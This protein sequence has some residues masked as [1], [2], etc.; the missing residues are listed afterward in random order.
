MA[1]RPEIGLALS[2]LNLGD[3]FRDAVAPGTYEIDALVHL[4]G[5][6]TVKPDIQDAKVAARVPWQRICAV[7][8][9]KLNGATIEAVVGEALAATEGSSRAFDEL[10]AAV[11]ARAAAA[12][13]RLLEGSRQTR[14]GAVSVSL[15]VVE[16][17]VLEARPGRAA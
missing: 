8:L 5:A 9:S 15:P 14:R 2:K 1:I 12:V 16:E 17:I 6:M 11:A 4:K 7:L 10:E 3:A 13:E